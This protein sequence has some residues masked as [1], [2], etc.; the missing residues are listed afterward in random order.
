MTLLQEPLRRVH[1][2]SSMA[3]ASAVSSVVLMGLRHGFGLLVQFNTHAKHPGFVVLTTMD[4]A[5]YS[6][7]IPTSMWAEALAMTTDNE[8]WR[9]PKAVVVQHEVRSED[10][11]DT[12]RYQPTFM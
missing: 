5:I 10:I 8:R 12:C 4:I 9:T 6:Q 3:E 1:C 2:Y 11:F 7:S